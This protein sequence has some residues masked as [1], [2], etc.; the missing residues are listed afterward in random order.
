[1]PVS[2]LAR[3]LYRL[4]WLCQHFGV[5]TKTLELSA[6]ELAVRVCSSVGARPAQDGRATSV[7][8]DIGSEE[9]W[10]EQGS[11]ITCSF[12]AVVKDDPPF[13]QKT[14]AVIETQ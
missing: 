1:M 14:P 4:L 10:M 3:G 9:V 5:K 12:S 2:S 6:D 13:V 11:G 8:V 7:A